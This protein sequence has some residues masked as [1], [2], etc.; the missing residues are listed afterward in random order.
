MLNPDIKKYDR[1]IIK[2]SEAEAK[3]LELTDP[4]EAIKK[5]EELNI[6]NPGLKKYNKRIEICKKKLN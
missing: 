4:S 3:E 1:A 6:L 5:Y 2:I